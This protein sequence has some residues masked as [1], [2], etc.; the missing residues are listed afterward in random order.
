MRVHLFKMLVTELV[1]VLVVAFIIFLSLEKYKPGFVLL[2]FRIGYVV[3]ALAVCL[4]FSF[5]L[6][7]RETRET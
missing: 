2:H 1:T 6:S 4:I 5:F 3:V 7:A